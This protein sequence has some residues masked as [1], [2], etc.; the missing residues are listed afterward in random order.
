MYNVGIG[1]C[2]TPMIG[3][4]TFHIKNSGE[5]F[6]TY[7]KNECVCVNNGKYTV[8][9]CMV[10]EPLFPCAGDITVPAEPV[11]GQE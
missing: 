4:A 3:N 1:D 8:V 2:S 11:H 7:R 9:M 6:A 10:L 5:I